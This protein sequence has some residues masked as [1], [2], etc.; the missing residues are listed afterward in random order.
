MECNKRGK[1]RNTFLSL[2]YQPYLALFKVKPSYMKKNFY[3]ILFLLMQFSLYSCNRSGP[4][5]AA[6]QKKSPVVKSVLI[7]GDSIHY[8]EIGSGDPVVFVH[9]TL[10]DYRG[11]KGQLDTFATKHRV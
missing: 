2:K 9:G 5:T 4:D 6:D 3:T 10:G 1:D 11:F 8:I 7:N